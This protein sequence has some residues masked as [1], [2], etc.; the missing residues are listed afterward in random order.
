MRTGAG[1]RRRYIQ[2]DGE[3]I[4]VP[5]NFQPEP[6]NSDAVLWN[7]RAYQDVGDPRFHSRTSHREFMR[8]EGLTT[9]DDFK[10]SFKQAR[11]KR[12]AFYRGEDTSRKADIAR[13]LEKV[14]G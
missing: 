8:R 3:L 5:L 4:E 6:R 13:A 14:R 1:V 12:L 2:R 11:E 9:V 7:D 10:D